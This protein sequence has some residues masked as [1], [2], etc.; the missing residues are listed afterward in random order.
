MR[1]T[2]LTAAGVALVIALAG[3]GGKDGGSA[4]PIDNPAQ[5]G[6]ATMFA[7][8]QELAQAATAQTQKSQSARFTFEMDMAGQKASGSGQGRFVGENPA[9]SMTMGMGGQSMEVRLVDN[10][11]YMKM[12]EG[13]AP[14]GMKPWIKTSLDGDDPMSQSVRQSLGQNDPAK[15]LDMIQEAGGKIV[16]SEQAQL[17]GQPTTHYVIEVDAV[18]M[19]EKQGQANPM[20][21]SAEGRQAM[22]Q[23]GTIPMELWLNGDQLPVQV[24]MD[25][26]KMMEAAGQAGQTGKMTMKYTDW[27]APVTIEAPP[28]DQVTER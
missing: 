23:I 1:R 10:A 25:M 16:K 2:A 11:L 17:D 3:C 13:S 12:P 27:G 22:E 7:S 6:G 4:T 20:L 14:E 28:A 21:D 15:T 19:M 24:V 8:I 9:M 18:K 5:G 26:S